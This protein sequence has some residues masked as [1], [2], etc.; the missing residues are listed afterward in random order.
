MEANQLYDIQDR[1]VAEDYHIENPSW[2]VEKELNKEN[3]NHN[4][5]NGGN[6]NESSNNNRN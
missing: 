6:R 3:K 5:S 1:I 2:I 4:G